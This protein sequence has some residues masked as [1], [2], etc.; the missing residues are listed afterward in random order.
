MRTPLLPFQVLLE[1]AQFVPTPDGASTEPASRSV[2]RDRLKVI[3]PRAD[4]LEAIFLASPA[5]HGEVVKWLANDKADPDL[6]QALTRYLQR[7]AS[8][9]TPF[10][11]FAGCSLGR[12]D[13]STDLVLAASSDYRRNA[14]ID[15]DY[16][17]AFAAALDRDPRV[18]GQALYRPNS[19]LYK[20][21]GR[22][23]YVERTLAGT[24]RRDNLVE[25]ED[26]PALSAA[27]A[28]CSQRATRAAIVEAVLLNA[29][30]YD[31]GQSEAEQYV[32]QL[33]DSQ[34]MVSELT[35]L[36]TGREPLADLIDQCRQWPSLAPETEVLTEV[37]RAIAELNQSALGA[38]LQR[39]ADVEAVVQTV[40]P[41]PARARLFQVDL[42]KPAPE[43][44]LGRSIVDDLCDVVHALH[45]MTP[46]PRTA[47][48]KKFKE[49]FVARYDRREIPLFEALD[50]ESGIGFGS[51]TEHAPLLNGLAFPSVA[52]PESQL[53]TPRDRVVL[54]KL[55]SVLRDRQLAMVLTEEDVAA[56]EQPRRLPGPDAFHVMV[57]IG[58]R[59][60]DA[61]EPMVVI[62]SIGG[63]SGANLLARFCHADPELTEA[64]KSH[65]QEEE[66]KHPEAMFAEVVHLPEGRLGNIIARPVLRKH[67]IV[68]LGRSGVADD[69][70][71]PVSD[72][73]VSVR[74]DR[75]VLRSASRGV[76]V[77]PRKT[78]AHNY[79]RGLG[80]YR[81][82]CALQMQGTRPFL[83]WE[84]G[85]LEAFSFLPRV[86]YRRC[87][88]ARARWR[89]DRRT[90]PKI[91]DGDL[92]D[93]VAAIRDWQTRVQAPRFCL[94]AVGDNELL[95]D[96]SNA[97]SVETL[98]EEIV[99]QREMTLT[100]MCPAPDELVAHGPEGRFVHEIVI[101]F[102]TNPM[103]AASPALLR[104]RFTRPIVRPRSF[105]PGTEWTYL[106][107]YAG[108][109]SVDTLLTRD[110]LPFLTSL[111]ERGHLDQWFFVRYSDPD[112][113][114]RVRLRL[115][116]QARD[117]FM[118][119]LAALSGD[120]FREGRLWRVQLDTYER[121]T[122]RYGG[123]V[124]VELAEELFVH[125]SHAVL[126]ILSGLSGDEGMAARWQM[127]L[128]SWHMTL[129]DFGFTTDERLQFV[130]NGAATTA[131]MLRVGKSLHRSLGDKYR[132]ERGAITRLLE[133][134]GARP[135]AMA[136]QIAALR[137]R[138]Q[139]SRDVVARIKAMVA[140]GESDASLFALVGSYL[141]MNANRLL[142]G[143]HRQQEFVIF[144]FL[145][146]YY[147]SVL[148][149]ARGRGARPPTTGT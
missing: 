130:R 116:A 92:P 44:R 142:R 29:G 69:C 91:W 54:T 96:F 71:L 132:A 25:L 53:W 45:R 127:C 34:V 119:R 72:L 101:P 133:Y 73:L 52:D 28:C 56:L 89:V 5:L 2:L 115:K 135:H 15:N 83:T 97:L 67:E 114:V 55:E 141:H 111:T 58:A 30:D 23:R 106:K 90:D 146:R 41:K 26:N 80:I 94:L 100:E 140:A 64:V 6:E 59:S 46:P 131:E 33:I 129:M 40:G 78:N 35:P 13:S 61:T 86:V 27:I 93:R 109:A 107:F 63:P 43:A 139:S 77:R 4:I 16:L 148:A 112:W 98:L 102:T 19:S 82:L 1:W 7:M 60:V 105:I 17:F 95:I 74:D 123:D 42:R 113:H 117:G 39:Y 108:T 118:D 138:S 128:L 50:D 12:L 76:E 47:L 8:R 84:W 126:Q 110:L 79:S 11:L 85:P 24:K 37:S 121:E 125:D 104:P 57:A 9:S 136:D 81:F 120:A 103:P 14:R 147:E 122:E 143:S 124:G 145:G 75:V 22:W 38:S 65:L 51:T 137:A 62:R 134:D 18:R 149:R 70:Q 99:R 66:A 10:G 87:V 88:L 20:I 144:D 31:V 49:A 21:A 32:E 48:F 3:L 68:F 36:V